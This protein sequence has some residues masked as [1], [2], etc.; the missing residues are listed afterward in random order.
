MAEQTCI[1]C[2][3]VA[4]EIPAKIVYQD[5][6]AVAFN[7]IN[8]QAPVHVLV[9]PREHSE[10]LTD[11]V[12]KDVSSVGQLMNAVVHVAKEMGL[13]KRYRT[14]INTGAEAGQ[15]VFH[16]HVHLLGGRPLSWPPG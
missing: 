8:P 6:H 14:V 4:G 15:S 1:F 13:P 7:D 16:L 9:I 12:E 11:A 5:E 3:I 2:K 10:S